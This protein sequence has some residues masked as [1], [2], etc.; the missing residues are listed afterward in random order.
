MQQRAAA[1][2]AVATITRV[3]TI[4]AAVQRVVSPHKP[5]FTRKAFWC[6]CVRSKFY[7][8]SIFISFAART[9]W[10]TFFS[11]GAGKFLL[12]PFSTLFVLRAFWLLLPQMLAKYYSSLLPFVSNNFLW[13][14]QN[15]FINM[16]TKSPRATEI[17]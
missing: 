9:F 6:L 1:A 13:K 14:C 11:E 5:P 4:F 2:V 15:P 8:S 12:L 3:P 16:H 10:H 7:I 17:V